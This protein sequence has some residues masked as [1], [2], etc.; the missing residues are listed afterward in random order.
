M[1][2]SD[3][4]AAVAAKVGSVNGTVLERVV[5]HYAEQEATRRVPLILAGLTEVDT[6]T[7]GL[8][9]FKATKQFNE[10]GSLLTEF[11][12]GKTIEE[13]NK[14]TTLLKKWEDALNKALDAA[15]YGELEKL[16]KSKG[17]GDKKQDASS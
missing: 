1:N 8:A 4:Q 2:I 11:W 3:F 16:V 17:Q 13:R 7:K 12:E 15:D 9:R 5:D 10:D 6:M 14:H